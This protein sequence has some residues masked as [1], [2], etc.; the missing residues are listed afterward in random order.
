MTK[1]QHWKKYL[2]CH[3]TRSNKNTIWVG[4][5]LIACIFVSVGPGFILL[6]PISDPVKK[7]GNSSQSA[8]THG[9]VNCRS[10]TFTLP[11]CTCMLR[12]ACIRTPPSFAPTLHHSTTQLCNHFQKQTRGHFGISS[13]KMSIIVHNLRNP[14]KWQH[15]YIQRCGLIFNDSSI[16]D[17][18]HV[19]EEILCA[20]SRALTSVETENDQSAPIFRLVVNEKM[21]FNDWFLNF[22]IWD[23][24]IFGA[25][26]LV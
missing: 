7:L 17:N 26:L 13:A 18:K 1:S 15:W 24:S 19:H 6:I 21:C 23:I 10:Y 20:L 2:K 16:L 5:Y 8:V 25:C 11:D 14:L 22:Y 3:I 12:A 9:T 4:V